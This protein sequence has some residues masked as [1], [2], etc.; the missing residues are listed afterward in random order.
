[1]RGGDTA[2]ER[3]SRREIEKESSAEPAG[4]MPG[5]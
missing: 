3:R 5:F 4:A 2:E 1:M